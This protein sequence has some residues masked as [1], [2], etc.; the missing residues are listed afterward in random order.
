[1]AEI[2]FLIILCKRN[3]L[4]VKNKGYSATKYIFQTLLIWFGTEFTGAIVVSFFTKSLIVTY[5]LVLIPAIIVSLIYRDYILKLKVYNEESNS[6]NSNVDNKAK[7]KRVF[8]LIIGCIL[9]LVS[10]FF[11]LGSLNVYVEYLKGNGLLVETGVVANIFSFL[12]L[13][14]LPGFLAYL[15]FVKASK[16]KKFKGNLETNS[17]G[18]D[19]D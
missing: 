18:N 16:A 11:F 1:M 6:D 2:I 17:I 4:T 8:F 19:L 15:S 12:V 7:A 5:I 10:C 9:A 3:A 14:V 13:V